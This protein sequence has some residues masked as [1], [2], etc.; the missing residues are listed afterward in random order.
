MCRVR[1]KESLKR[2]GKSVNAVSNL[3]ELIHWTQAMNDYTDNIASTDSE[4][5][6]KYRIVSE[7]SLIVLEFQDF[8]FDN[9]I[10][11]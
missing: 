6:I 8:F 9:R 4:R 11:L 10:E 7:S 2:F 1:K 3:N 5:M